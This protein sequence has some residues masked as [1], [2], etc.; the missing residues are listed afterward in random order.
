MN[1]MSTDAAGGT[2]NRADEPPYT[3]PRTDGLGRDAFLTM[4]VTQLQHQDPTQPMADGEFITQLAQFST[5]EKLTE[6]AEAITELRDLLVDEA[7]AT[8]E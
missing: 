1:V 5:L 4:L 3:A 8:G 7:S 6:I 2:A